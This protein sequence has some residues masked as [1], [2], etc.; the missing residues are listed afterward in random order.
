MFG[1]EVK[2]GAGVGAA[3]AVLAEGMPAVPRG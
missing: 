2:L 3:Q 1:H